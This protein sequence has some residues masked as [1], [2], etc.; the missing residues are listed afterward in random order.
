MEEYRD[1]MPN[2]LKEQYDE[3]KKIKKKEEL[4]ENY[5]APSERSQPRSNEERLNATLLSADS[6]LR[7]LLDICESICNNKTYD[8]NQSENAINDYFRDMLTAKGYAQIMD[9]TRHGV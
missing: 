9:Q 4:G 1:L 5:V 8:Y 3:N 6:V 7:D 2:D